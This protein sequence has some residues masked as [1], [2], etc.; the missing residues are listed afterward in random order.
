MPG[1]RRFV[2]AAAAAAVAIGLGHRAA[3][4]Q[5]AER[6]VRIGILR[7][8]A[9]PW[10]AD[11][12]T[13]EV[14]LPAALA[15]QGYAR[16]RNLVIEA[17]YGGGDAQRIAA[18]AREL[19]QLRVD[20]IVA[21]GSAAIVAAKQATTT[22]PIVM[23]GNFD[24]VAA[25]FV[26]SLARPGGNV[27]GVLIAPEGTLGAK[28]LELLK[29]AVPGARRVAVLAPE[30]PGSIAVQLPELRQAAGVLKLDLPVVA[31]R[32][33]DYADAFARIAATRADA[34]FVVATT[35]FFSD[36]RPIIDLANRHRLP[37]IW[38]WREQVQDGGLMAYGTSLAARNQ[39]IAEV[40]DQILKG[41]NPGEIP[42]DR[43]V[44]FELTIN[45]KAAKA[46]GLALPQ[47]LLLRADEVIQS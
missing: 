24:P 19:A 34:L 23:W 40:I 17:R 12:Y 16:G 42:V 11:Q 18:L 1:R 10:S 41:A 27:T 37:A 7:P 33:G 44:R 39:R 25:G 20:V 21:V 45:L 28:K 4:A 5:P 9:E 38:E 26:A 35:Y 2:R 6:T 32:N 8:T 3:L 30:D 15:K 22:I 47:A 46:I 43:P 13:S 14:L 36:R 31:V 29:E